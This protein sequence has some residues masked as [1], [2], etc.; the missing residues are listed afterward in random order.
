MDEYEKYL[1][2]C[3]RI[4]GENSLL[5]AEFSRLMQSEGLAPKT[6]EKHVSNMTF[7]LN[8]FLLYEA[9]L[10]AR[11]GIDKVDE[12]L[13]HWFIR[14]ALWASKTAIRDY[15]AG[16]KRFYTFMHAKG[17]VSAAALHDL[18]AE[19]KRNRHE[20]LDSPG[21]FDEPNIDF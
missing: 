13:G 12:F 9:P 15:I 21:R 1:A 8:H 5:L 10:N 16:L 17:L 20:W 4:K 6:I 3:E 19:I 7:Y 14:K 2:A 11:Q 18:E